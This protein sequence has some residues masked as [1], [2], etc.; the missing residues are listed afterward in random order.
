MTRLSEVLHPS[1]VRVSAGQHFAGLRFAVEA[2]L[3]LAV[4][5]GFGRFAFTA[6]YPH[7]RDTAVS[8]E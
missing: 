6:I 5:M 8:A 2:A 1:K 4:G 3:I 7:M